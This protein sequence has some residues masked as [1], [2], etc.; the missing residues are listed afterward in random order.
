MIN[1]LSLRLAWRNLWR[2]PRRTLLTLSALVLSLAML[3]FF[4]N[5]MGGMWTRIIRV[6]TSSL[7]GQGQ[8]HQ[9][10]YRTTED[11]ETVIVD[12]GATL[13]TLRTSPEIRGV[14]ARILSPA[15]T[16][17]GDRSQSVRLIGIDP[18]AE[19]NVT[20]WPQRVYQGQYLSEGK[21]ALIGKRLAERLE[22]E[23]GSSLVVTVADI[24]TGDLNS[25][26]LKIEGII[27]TQNPKV[28]G[29][30]IIVTHAVA[31][32]LTG[33]NNV[34]HEI[35]VTWNSA[36][37]ADVATLEL[38]N[39]QLRAENWQQLIPGMAQAYNLQAG[40]LWFTFAVVF[41]LVA[42][43][44]A[45]TMNMSLIERHREFGVMM[46]LGTNDGRLGAMVFTEYVLLGGLGSLLGLLVGLGVTAALAVNGIS[47][48]GVEV[49]GYA[50]DEPLYPQID[51]AFSL[52]QTATFWILTP[53][54]SY[55]SILRL[56]RLEPIEVLRG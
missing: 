26:L 39:D 18:T 23:V 9:A 6:A 27:W 55:G 20:S 47:L 38:P 2:R 56:R 4:G 19:G 11:P 14:S 17:M 53:L 45:N 34:A 10:D 15:L 49:M 1:A 32:Q 16:A 28:D 8:I 30:S 35:A 54:I 21:N 22:L 3:I 12:R 33:L 43:S 44:I 13:A 36:L 51:W 24:K 52:S 41:L 5:L 37:A 46:A 29:R 31:E 42:L 25:L 7:V 50:M 40:Y 48:S